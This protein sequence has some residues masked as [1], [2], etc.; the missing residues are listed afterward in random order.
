MRAELSDWVKANARGV[1]CNEPPR[2]YPRVINYLLRTV[3]V[4]AAAPKE[5]QGNQM[6][7]MFGKEAW[8]SS[9]RSDTVKN[10]EL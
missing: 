5:R 6:Y 10:G 1:M 7:S 9:R 8:I 2:G 3:V 4:F